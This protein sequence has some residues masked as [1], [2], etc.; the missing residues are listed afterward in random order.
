M[1]TQE[2]HPALIEHLCECYGRNHKDDMI[3]LYQNSH[4]RWH[5]VPPEVI[6]NEPML[7]TAR[8]FRVRTVFGRTPEERRWASYM[9][10]LIVQPYRT[11]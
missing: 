1:T 10:L 3:S 5:G 11:A 6:A 9:E 4:R 7:I 8:T 2:P